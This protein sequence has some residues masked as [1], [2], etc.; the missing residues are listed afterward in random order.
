MY[1]L[2]KLIKCLFLK[3][4]NLS[5]YMLNKHSFV[6]AHCIEV[7]KV[8]YTILFKKKSFTTFTLKKKLIFSDWRQ[9]QN[10]LIPNNYLPHLNP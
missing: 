10:F 8:G 7:I 3:Q 2:S 4:Q 9:F 5:T 6:Q 1:I